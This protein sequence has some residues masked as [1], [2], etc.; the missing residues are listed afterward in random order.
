MA[1]LG[2]EVL[3]QLS[4]L[5]IILDSLLA[6]KIGLKLKNAFELPYTKLILFLPFYF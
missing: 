2:F 3:G 1:H 4:S 6:Q 5:F